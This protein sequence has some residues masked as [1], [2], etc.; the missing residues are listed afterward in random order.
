MHDE[1]AR[2][3][4]RAIC[5]A[6]LEAGLTQL[7][8]ATAI[9]VGAG[10]VGIWERGRVSPSRGRPAFVPK[11]SREQ[12]EAI[13]AALGCGVDAIAD[14]AALSANTRVVLGLLPMGPDRTVVGGITYDLSDAELARVHDFIAG[15]IAARDLQCSPRAGD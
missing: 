2:S 4:G 1:E 3:L 5:S 13:A 9:G 10:Q 14:R 11:V 7:K 12:L 15:I 6:R 8:L